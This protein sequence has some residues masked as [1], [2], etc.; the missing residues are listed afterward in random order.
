[1]HPR[2][3]RSLASISKHTS[4]VDDPMLLMG[5]LC[6]VVGCRCCLFENKR[7]RMH[8]AASGRWFVSV[9]ATDP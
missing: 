7:L 2:T 4:H 9:D 5:I 1:M 8:Y 3:G 6:W